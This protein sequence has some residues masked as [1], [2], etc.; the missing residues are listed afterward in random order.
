MWLNWK[1]L[2][3]HWYIIFIYYVITMIQTFLSIKMWFIININFLIDTITTMNLCYTLQLFLNLILTLTKY[4][5]FIFPV[6]HLLIVPSFCVSHLSF[7]NKFQCFFLV[8]CFWTAYQYSD[9]I[10]LIGNTI[11]LEL[12]SFLKIH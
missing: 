4:L 1:K 12:L 8:L 6:S 7:A 2:T 10:D 3:K 5:H 9:V 11:R